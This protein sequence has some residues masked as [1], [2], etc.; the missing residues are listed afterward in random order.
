MHS[1]FFFSEADITLANDV[2]DV[3]AFEIRGK[4][5]SIA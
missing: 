1:S 3:N 5:Q 2:L 4:N